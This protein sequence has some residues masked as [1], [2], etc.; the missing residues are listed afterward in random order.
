MEAIEEECRP[1]LIPMLRNEK[2]LLDANSCHSLAKWV[3]LRVLIAQHAAPE[4]LRI[5]PP[6]TYHRFYRSRSLPSGAQVWMGRY[7]GTGMW[8]CDYHHLE[9]TIAGPSGPEPSEPNGYFV[10]FVVGYVAFLC[11][12]HE[13]KGGERILNLSGGLDRYFV[14]IW[15]DAATVTWPPEGVLGANGLEAVI[16]TLEP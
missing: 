15:P 4:N 9:L 3:T 1:I 10:A 12:G 6:G 2:V 8:P 7:N 16:R 11:F 13:I 5:I 14:P